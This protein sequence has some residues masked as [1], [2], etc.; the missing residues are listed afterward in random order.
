MITF[1]TRYE[2][3]LRTTAT[4]A[5]SGVT[6][7]TDAPVDN[8]G[9][10]EA[11]SPTD[12]LS[13]SLVSCMLT[14]MGISAVKNN[15]SINGTDVVAQKIM[16]SNPRRIDEIIIEIKLPDINYSTGEKTLIIN[17]AMN[18]PVVKSIHPDL[19]L[20]VTFHFS[21]EKLFKTNIL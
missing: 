13:A 18:C 14:I 1:K 20:K 15:Y 5:S 7:F 17:A 19:K 6:I 10:G 16:A 21:D 9:R 4:H 8:M 3:D 12:L 11:F 2:G